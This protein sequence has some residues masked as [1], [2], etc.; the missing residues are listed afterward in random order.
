MKGFCRLIDAI[1]KHI[2]ETLKYAIILIVFTMSIEIVMRYV[3][4]APT[5]WAPELTQMIF[6][7]YVVLAGG[8]VLLCGGHVNVDIFITT[9]SARNRIKL[10]I[11]TSI[12]FFIFS[13]VLVYFGFSLA[14][15]SI[16]IWESSTSA[17]DPP[18]WPIKL[19]IP[20][21]AVLL[22][23]QGVSKLFKDILFLIEGVDLAADQNEQKE[24]L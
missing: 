1:N 11:F 9:V 23:L 4:N 8:Y 5:V 2:G 7:I 21:G 18:I 6:G 13:G 17:W 20:T 16:A 10:D 15:D 22:L 14:H 3:F 24:T 19:M 12:V